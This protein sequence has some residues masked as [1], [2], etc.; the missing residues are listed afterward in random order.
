MSGILR[1]NPRRER[2]EPGVQRFYRQEM[3]CRKCKQRRDLAGCS[4][5][6][7]F[8]CRECVKGAA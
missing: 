8:T 4:R 6:G 2:N 7:G 3:E 1:T 5:K